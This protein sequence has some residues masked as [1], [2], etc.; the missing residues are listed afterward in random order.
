MFSKPID[1]YEDVVETKLILRKELKIK[2]NMLLAVFANQKKMKF[3]RL[4][5]KKYMHSTTD[6]AIC[7]IFTTVRR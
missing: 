1:Y 3:F 7:N 2:K 5:V 6:T 4:L